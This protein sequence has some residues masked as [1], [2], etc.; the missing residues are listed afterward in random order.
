VSAAAFASL[1]GER[2]QDPELPVGVFERAAVAK[3]ERKRALEALFTGRTE[4]P[5]DKRGRWA[6]FDGGARR[7]VPHR[8][9]PEQEHDEII[10]QMAQL[11]RAFG[12]RF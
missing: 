5:R 7:S 8:R 11:S 6:G 2:R 1:V 10:V 12:A 3:A 9:P 4:Q